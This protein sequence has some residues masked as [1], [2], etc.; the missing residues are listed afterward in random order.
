MELF[1][2]VKDTSE[3]ENER[4]NLAN[5][6]K[7]D[8]LVL[9]YLKENNIPVEYI[10]KYPM[11]FSRLKKQM[12]ICKS[13]SGLNCCNSS[14]KG[15]LKKIV[16][17]D[18][19]I[20]E[21]VASCKYKIKKEK[22]DKSKMEEYPYLKKYLINDLPIDQR[23]VQIENIDVL[24]EK[25]PKYLA[26]LQTI[27]RWLEAEK[28][29]G[30]YLHGSVGVGK[31][32]L[33]ACIANRFAKENKSIVFIHLPSYVVRLKKAFDDYNEYEYL[34][35]VCMSCDLLVMD[36]IGAE[37]VSN[38]LRDEV[39]LPILNTRMNEKKLTI[40]TSNLDID[41]LEMK[42]RTS[43]KGQIDEIAAQRLVDRIR[44]LSESLLISG[45][46]RRL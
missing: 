36:D 24:K 8:T 39:L 35:S 10:D 28:K 4:I 13:C 30:L 38:W 22:E 25:H 14:N 17:D 19:S 1:D 21:I 41:E 42:Y 15:Y 23:N 34:I 43:N 7:K 46:N 44:V 18:G 37:P 5:E 40:F 3:L 2:I 31:T 45:I 16:F 9:K 20:K 32:Y 26:N 11:K 27:K 33:A 29:K 12:D 6:L